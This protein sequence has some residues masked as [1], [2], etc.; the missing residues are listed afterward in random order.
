MVRV[1]SGFFEISAEE[2][3]KHVYHL[4]GPQAILHSFRVASSLDSLVVGENQ[5][6]GQMKKAYLWARHNQ[7]LGSELSRWWDKI[8]WIGKK[9]RTETSIGQY[10]VSVGSAAIE[11]AERLFGSLHNKHVVCVGAG[12]I[13]ERMLRSLSAKSPQ[14]VSILNRTVA[15]AEALA[16]QGLG[17]A[18][19][20]E[21][22]S[23]K[24]LEADLIITSL[25]VDY[26][27][28][29]EADVERLMIE[30][31]HRPLFMI[32][33]G[34]PRNIDP[35][36]NDLSNVYLFNIDDLKDVVHES[37][38]LRAN[39]QE[40]AEALVEKEA[41]QFAG[42]MVAGE[43]IAA[44]LARRWQLVAQNEFERS[45]VDAPDMVA[46]GQRATQA[47]VRRLVGDVARA[48]QNA[49]PEEQKQMESLLGTIFGVCSDANDKATFDTRIYV[50]EGEDYEPT[51]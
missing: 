24:Q 48:Y 43:P 29:S 28:F 10:P 38:M 44:R 51:V 18:F 21:A 8:L 42:L 6:L 27:L 45:L 26:P 46:L 16:E 9:I 41:V 25:D 17:Q 39:E 15:R 30:R 19:G 13:A 22:L 47:I 40:T 37:R 50:R 7:N 2:L 3:L 11:Q 49:S 12:K 14:S 32:D 31:R 33:L 5:I 23:S 1:L 35:R 20:L 4:E 36:V 34:L